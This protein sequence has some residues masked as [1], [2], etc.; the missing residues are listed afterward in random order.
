MKKLII[1]FL[2]IVLLLL[3]G[4]CQN[5][6]GYIPIKTVD[7]VDELYSLKGTFV[8]DNSKIVKIIDKAIDL[9]PYNPYERGGV[10]LITD[11]TPYGIEIEYT[12]NAKPYMT[13]YNDDNYGLDAR[14]TV[15]ILFA[16]VDNVEFI[17]FSFSF[18]QY[19]NEEHN[20]ASIIESFQ[21]SFDYEN[22]TTTKDD[23]RK[24]YND[25]IAYE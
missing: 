7:V 8:G 1:L 21:N 3:L 18:D 23:F 5:M 9:S 13:P 20:R 25:L 11:K 12:Q 14:K 19:L 24:F 16:L 6:S 4:A 22:V 2:I 17:K 15:A 10:K